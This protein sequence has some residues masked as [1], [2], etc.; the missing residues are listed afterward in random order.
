MMK[1]ADPLVGG[2]GEPDFAAVLGAAARV[3][4]EAAESA[5]LRQ[6]IFSFV[7][8]RSHK[9]WHLLSSS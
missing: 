8:P 2:A 6:T 5:V 3:A 1:D 9:L 4:F 7:T